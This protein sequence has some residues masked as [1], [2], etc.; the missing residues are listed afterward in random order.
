MAR[1]IAEAKRRVAEAQ[2]KLAV[3]DNPYMV[4]RDFCPAL[5]AYIR[6]TDT[7]HPVVR[8]SAWQEEEQ[9]RHP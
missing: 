8:A 6:D 4:R 5:V 2:S 3:K 7:R 1:R 9:Q